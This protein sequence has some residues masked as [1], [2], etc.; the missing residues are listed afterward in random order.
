MGRST[1]TKKKAVNTFKVTSYGDSEQ[2]GN[3]K[4][5]S[6]YLTQKY[7]EAYKSYEAAQEMKTGAK[8]MGTAAKKDATNMAVSNTNNVVSQMKAFNVGT[9]KYHETTSKKKSL[10]QQLTVGDKMRAMTP[11]KQVAGGA[12]TS[13]NAQTALTNAGGMEGLVGNLK[14]IGLNIKKKAKGFIVS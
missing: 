5:Y 14:G 12:S 2:D 8:G 7:N 6:G 4:A 9:V 13:A 3:R 1:Q 10:L 11:V